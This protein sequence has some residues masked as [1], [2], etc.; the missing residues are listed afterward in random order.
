MEEKVMPVEEN[1]SQEIPVQFPKKSNLPIIV[2]SLIVILLIA[3][4]VYAGIQIG[5][6]QAISNQIISQPPEVPTSIP[7][8]VP[9]ITNIPASPDTSQGGPTP[10][11]TANWKSY[12]NTFFNYSYKYPNDWD[13]ITAESSE[14]RNLGWSF[15]GPD[16]NSNGGL[17]GVEIFPYSKTIDEY[18]NENEQQAEVKYLSKSGL[19]INGIKGVMVQYEGFP[20]SGY[21]F[22]FKKSGYVVNIQVG[23]RETKDVEVFNQILSTFKFTE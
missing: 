6:K 4:G 21:G 5:K 23:S 7:T 22:L 17:G 15:F 20:V 16:P 2:I 10:D 18:L 9:E 3:T 11:A 8:Q 1:P 14:L 19:T 12:T 13:A